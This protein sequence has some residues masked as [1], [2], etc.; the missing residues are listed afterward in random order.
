MRSQGEKKIADY[1]YQNGIKYTYE[2]PAKTTT[3]AFRKK[4]SQ[5]DFYLPDHQVYVE[6]WGLVDVDD[7]D[8]RKKYNDQKRLKERAYEDNGIKFVSIYPWHLDDL[9]GAFKSQYRK[10][11]KR[12][13]VFGPIGE[14]MV[15]ALPVSP[16]LTKLLVVST[17]QNA[18]LLT[19]SEV[20]VVFM[21]YYFIAYDCFVQENFMY[22]KINL[23][24]SGLLVIEANSGNL[25]DSATESG[26][27]PDIQRTRYF[28]D[29]VS[30]QQKEVPRA[31]IFEGMTFSKVDALL[32]KT[33][34]E[35]AKQIARIAL[36]KYLYRTHV[37]TTTKGITHT[38]TIRPSPNSV[39]ITSTKLVNIP[40]I[41]GVFA[42]KNK[43]YR[44]TIQAA[45]GKVIVDDFSYCFAPVRHFA[46]ATLICE[47]CGDLACSR[48]GK[49]CVVC[50]LSFCLR[51]ITEKGLIFKKYYCSQ[52][53][54]P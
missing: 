37:Y 40:I 43:T 20:H 1:F 10:V 44:R 2:D 11:M 49:N 31:K 19:L 17:L 39:R 14:R 47:I 41:T 25:I 15:H 27:R 26:D 4:I 48:D 35:E 24:S 13:F 30:L 42:Y 21:P 45:T 33:T 51:H 5:P 8:L 23:T 22:H 12:D 53:T 54:P 18:P 52:H 50:G 32:S 9:D 16:L 34:E 3:S 29:C 46:I 28:T 6:Y 36:A 38:R 7:P